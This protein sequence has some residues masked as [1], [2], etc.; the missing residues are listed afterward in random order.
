LLRNAPEIA[1]VVSFDDMLKAPILAAALPLV[2]E[3]AAGSAVAPP[4]PLRDTDVTQLQE[5]L[6]RHGLPKIGRDTTHEAIDLRAQERSFHPVR[7]YLNSLKWDGA[8][9]LNKWLT[10]Y[11][12]ADESPYH[13]GIGRMF[14]IAMVARIYEPGAK[15]DYMLMLEGPQGARKSTACA[16][17][18]GPWFSDSL[19]DVMHDRTSRSISAANG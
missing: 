10:Y 15:C 12:G 18:A 6:Q 16:I 14:V 4:R 9:R 3:A 17:L 8:N 1:E 7:D 5:R 11:L 19:P 2:E 13:S